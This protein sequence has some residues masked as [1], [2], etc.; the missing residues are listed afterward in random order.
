MVTSR[1][2]L[3]L[4]AGIA[5]AAALLSFPWLAGPR[6][7]PLPA[8]FD[9][10]TP[11]YAAIGDLLA[12]LAESCRARDLGA[13]ARCV[14]P[15]FLQRWQGKL[16]RAGAAIEG[17]ALSE[18]AAA[19]GGFTRLHERPL[20]AGAAARQRVAMVLEAAS[21][22]TGTQAVAMVWDGERLLLDAIVQVPDVF[23][24][25]ADGVRELTATLLRPAVR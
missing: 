18:Y 9:R 15:A 24:D 4:T 6:P 2:G 7:N 16:D 8:T 1:R 11:G 21:G 3:C 10:Q 14:T 19:H 22:R 13:F 25:D 12:R 23:A 5:L 20:A 17:T